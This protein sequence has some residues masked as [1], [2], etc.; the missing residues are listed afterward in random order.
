MVADASN[1]KPAI[2]FAAWSLASKDTGRLRISDMSNGK[3]WFI[4]PA[5]STVRPLANSC[6]NPAVS[7]I[8]DL[9]GDGKSDVVIADLGSFFPEDHHRGKVVWIAGAD[10]DLV[11][12]ETTILQ[13]VGRIADVRAA[14]FDG[15]GDEDLVVAEFGRHL[16]GGIHL[17]WNE[18][19]DE[20][21]GQIRFRDE[22]LDTR[23]GAIHVPAV[24]LNGD[25]RMD[26]IALFSQEYEVVVAFL[27]LPGGFQK[28]TIFAAPD[29]SFGSSGIEVIDFDQDGDLDVIYTNGDTFDSSE[30]KPFHS[31][32]W[33]ENK[34][35]FPFDVHHV[36]TM[37]GVHRARTADIDGDGDLD[38][39]ASAMI[40]KKL[41]K[42][43][44]N[45]PLDAV[46]WLE[47][48]GHNSFERHVLATGAPIHTTV[49][50]ADMDDDG[51][52]DIAASCFYF[53]PEVEHPAVI[54]YWNEGP[55]QP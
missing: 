25:G 50:V 31:I 40:P 24:D 5:T 38:I 36:A 29:P 34:G 26:F 19:R 32:K 10:R 28:T 55:V 51:D 37:P 16:T 13:N 21:S 11:H 42:R 3:I 17:I 43:A 47:N 48:T 46:V 54:I 45:V 12:T 53:E 35:A 14:D 23:P 27:N 22:K 49:E 9:D 7:C 1:P 8:C 15:D 18:G 52:I 20:S 39:V 6:T 44:V 33:F 2:S 30:I 4:E 41:F